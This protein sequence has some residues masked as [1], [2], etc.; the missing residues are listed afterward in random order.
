MCNVAFDKSIGV[1]IGLQN[2][3]EGDSDYYSIAVGMPSLLHGDEVDS[4]SDDD[5]AR[6]DDKHHKITGVNDQNLQD[7]IDIV[8][9]SK[10]RFSKHAQRKA[11]VVRRFQH[12]EGHPS[13]ET[14][15]CSIG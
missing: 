1:N 12:A 5:D 13:D 10:K 8:V 6:L 2:H 15:L 9:K 3:G 11:N 14:M 7:T 4:D